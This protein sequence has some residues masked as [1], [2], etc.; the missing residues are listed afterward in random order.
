MKIV[1]FKKKSLKKNK[2]R[3]F[4]EKYHTFWKNIALFKKILQNKL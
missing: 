1:Y 3:I 4:E 2:N